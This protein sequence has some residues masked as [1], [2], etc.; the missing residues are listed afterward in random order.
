VWSYDRFVTPPAR[1]SEE[2]LKFDATYGFSKDEIRKLERM[3]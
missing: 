3:E 1:I 2:I